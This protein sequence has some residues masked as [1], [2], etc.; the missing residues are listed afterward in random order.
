MKILACV[1]V[2]IGLALLGCSTTGSGKS[3]SA[4]GKPLGAI[5]Q[6][7]AGNRIE[8]FDRTGRPARFV[9][10]GQKGSVSIHNKDE[11][12]QDNYAFDE[13]H[14]IIKHQRSYGDDYKNSKWQTAK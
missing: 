3:T 13:N 7:S 10:Q 12:G 1:V 11:T 6:A 2:A 9:P 4:V 14:I 8:F 5:L